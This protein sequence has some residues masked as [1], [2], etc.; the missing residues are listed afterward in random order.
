MP[1][2]QAELG[3]HG[4]QFVLAGRVGTDRC[5]QSVQLRVLGS[6]CAGRD[7]NLRMAFQ[8]PAENHHV[9]G[10]VLCHIG[11]V[12]LGDQRQRQVDT[13][14]HP[15]RCPDVAVAGVDRFALDDGRGMAGGKRVEMAPMSRRAATVEQA[16]RGER[17]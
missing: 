6:W 4:V 13:G 16:G 12:V 17:E 2:A 9:L 8:A 5:H 1:W 3:G 11:P 7:R 14:R 15:G 10:N